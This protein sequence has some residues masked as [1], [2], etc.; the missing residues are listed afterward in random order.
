MKAQL[1]AWVARKLVQGAVYLVKHPEV[2]KAVVD[3][4]KAS[5][6]AQPPV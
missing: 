1:L 2:V 4:I 3:D 6:G 5:R